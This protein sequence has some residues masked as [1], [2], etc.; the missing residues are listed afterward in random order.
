MRDYY[1][2]ESPEAGLVWVYR[3]RPSA[4]FAAEAEARWFLQG[5]YA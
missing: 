3:E 4:P 2:A 5:L 1:I